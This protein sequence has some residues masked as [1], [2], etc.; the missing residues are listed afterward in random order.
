MTL[1]LNFEEQNFR[2]MCQFYEDELR[3]ILRGELATEVLKPSERM[4][5]R[6]RRARAKRDS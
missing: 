6:R 2:N 4:N 1:D 3:R 5:L